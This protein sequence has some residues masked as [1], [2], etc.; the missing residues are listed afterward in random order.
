MKLASAPFRY[1]RTLPP[2]VPRSRGWFIP[3]QKHIAIATIAKLYRCSD[4]NC[5][6]PD[7]NLVSDLIIE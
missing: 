6:D 2:S 3:M 7:G 1:R 4:I 5:R